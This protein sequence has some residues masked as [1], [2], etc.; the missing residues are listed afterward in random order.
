[1]WDGSRV[2][3]KAKPSPANREIIMDSAGYLASLP[4]NSTAVGEIVKQSRGELEELFGFEDEEVPE[5]HVDE[6]VLRYVTYASPLA[7]Y[8][9][10]GYTSLS[11]F[12]LYAERYEPGV[13]LSESPESR[14]SN[15]DGEMYFGMEGVLEELTQVYDE[16]GNVN[17]LEIWLETDEGKYVFTDISF[18]RYGDES[19]YYYLSAEGLFL[20]GWEEP[21]P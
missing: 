8:N 6:P 18:Q 4:G 9:I 16:G 15:G 3:R 19:V 17:S 12:D 5:P 10:A 2:I 13:P 11:G 1:M 20:S 7:G 14:V 21:G